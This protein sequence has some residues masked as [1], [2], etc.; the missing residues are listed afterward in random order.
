METKVGRY[1]RGF[2]YM[3]WASQKSLQEVRASVH[4]LKEEGKLGEHNREYA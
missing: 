3:S 4:A 2:T 1:G